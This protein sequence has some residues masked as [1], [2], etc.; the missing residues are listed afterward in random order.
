MKKWEINNVVSPLTPILEKELKIPQLFANILAQRGVSN[1]EEAKQFF[2]P[3]VLDFIDPFLMLNMEKAVARIILAKGN[4]EKI[5]VYGDYDVDGTCSVAL[6]YLF[7][8]QLGVDV[9]HYQ[10]D[11]Y[12]EGYGISMQG[13]IWAKKN[14]INLVIALDCGV[15]AIEPSK[16]LKKDGIDLII[17]D[18]HLPGNKLPFSVAML[19]PKQG[20]CP[21]PF[22]DLCGCGIGFKLIQATAKKLSIK[23]EVVFSYLDLVAIATAADIVPMVGENRVL[24]KLGLERINENPRKGIQEL[25]QF[26][27]RKGII[28]SSDLV[29]AISPRINAAGRLGHASMA[30]ELL[31]ANT[32]EEAHKCAQL[33]EELNLERR[34]IDKK[35]TE[36]ALVLLEDE[37]DKFTSVVCSSNWHKGVVGIVASRLIETYYRPTVVLCNDGEFITGSVRS[38]K[39]F[40]VHAVLVKIGD[41][42]E[43]FGGHKY[44]AGVTLLP[45]KLAEFKQR[46]EAE[47]KDLITEDLLVEKI[48]IDAVLTPMD[49]I[50]DKK[51]NPFP[52]LYRLVDQLAPFGPGNMRPVFKLDNMIN[53]GYTKVVGET[54]LK[55][56]V[57]QM[58]GN[59]TL[60]GIGFGLGHL[61]PLFKETQNGV[62]IA[63]SLE[64]NEYNGNITVQLRVRDLKQAE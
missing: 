39:G 27:K 6:M 24:V 45:E 12:K 40:D 54:H 15:K 17:C 21:Y 59:V 33:I 3:S 48:K 22:K 58:G 44:A 11:R 28:E 62:D 7:L 34:E 31:A 38:V 29:F 52:K 19:N 8:K 64:K 49:L 61:K 46:F 42:F 51:T 57:K 47:V 2:R 55:L 63:F 13:V 41:I 53:A 37:K 9:C 23:D 26:S 50:R 43:R 25:I 35:T 30:V 56:N 32:I 1:F 10:P 20:N 60:D 16:Q 4:N 36:E 14:N 18:H 5:L